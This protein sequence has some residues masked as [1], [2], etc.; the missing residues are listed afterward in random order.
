MFSVILLVRLDEFNPM[1]SMMSESCGWRSAM[2][3]NLG[4][5]PTARNMTASPAFSAAGQNAVPSESQASVGGVRPGGT[6]TTRSTPASSIIGSRT[7]R[8]RR[9][10]SPEKCPPAPRGHP[11]D[12]SSIA[13]WAL[14]TLQDA[15]RRR[16]PERLGTAVTAAGSPALASQPAQAARKRARLRRVLIQLRGR[17][18]VRFDPTLRTQVGHLT[19]SEKCQ[20]RSSGITTPIEALGE[21]LAPPAGAP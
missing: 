21:H 5:S 12:S 13:A 17:S 10:G 15:P 14:V 4:T 6:M 9:A 11:A 3:A 20:E 1:W 2:W 7:A 18:N 16:L 8:C 19:K